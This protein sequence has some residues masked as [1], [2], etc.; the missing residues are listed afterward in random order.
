M[1][2]S[3]PIAQ[4]LIHRLGLRHHCVQISRPGMQWRD[5]DPLFCVC[6]PL[7]ISAVNFL[8]LGCCL[9]STENL[10]LRLW[11]LL[12]LLLP[13][14]ARCCLLLLA[15]ARFAIIGCSH[16]CSALCCLVIVVVA[17]VSCA[18]PFSFQFSGFVCSCLYEQRACHP[19]KR[20]SLLAV[21]APRA[22]HKLHSASAADLQ[23]NVQIS[24]VFIPH[25]NIQ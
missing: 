5:G 20:S 23:S 3:I 1:K 12:L 10:V 24:P 2:T 13:A 6:C 9:V 22:T 18:Y 11:L 14:L 8:K 25:T 19:A 4:V 15:F 17:L 21:P 7:C 16:F